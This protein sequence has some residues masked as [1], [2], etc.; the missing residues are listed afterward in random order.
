MKVKQNEFH[1]LLVEGGL[2]NLS[3][4]LEAKKKRL[5]EGEEKPER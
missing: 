1:R 3:A 2:D 5:L 4:A